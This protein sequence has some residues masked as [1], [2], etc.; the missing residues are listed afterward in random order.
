[1]KTDQLSSS[2]ET[3]KNR[4]FVL[5]Q[6][7]LLLIL[8][9]IKSFS[10]AGPFVVGAVEKTRVGICAGQSCVING[11][12]YFYYGKE[13]GIALKTIPANSLDGT[14]NQNLD[15]NSLTNGWVDRGLVLE[16]GPANSGQELISWPGVWYDGGTVHLVF[17]GGCSN[18][19]YGG[20][21]WYATST[22]TDP[23]TGK[24]VGYHFTRQ[25]TG[26]T[27]D[28]PI[29]KHSEINDCDFDRVDVGNPKIFEENNTW[30]L[31][32]HG[33]K[34]ASC[35]SEPLF[36][37]IGLAY[38]PNLKSL[39][40]YYGNPIISNITAL[41]GWET[42]CVGVG[43]VVKRNGLYYMIYEAIRC[44]SDW[45]FTWNL[46]TTNCGIG[47]GLACSP[48]LFKWSRYSNNPIA[49]SETNTAWNNDCPVIITYS[50][51]VDYVHSRC[52]GQQVNYCSYTNNVCTAGS[53]CVDWACYWDVT[54]GGFGT[55][56][57]QV[58]FSATNFVLE[59]E[60]ASHYYGSQYMEGGVT[61]WECVK[62]G[63]W[64]TIPLTYG[65]YTSSIP[66]GENVAT[67]VFKGPT[68]TGYVTI[69]T[70][71]AKLDICTDM[72]ATV[73]A[74]RI[75]TP[76]DYYYWSDYIY[77]KVPY[78]LK[79]ASANLEF[80]VTPLLQCDMKVDKIY[81]TNCYH[82]TFEAEAPNSENSNASGYLFHGASLEEPNA[83]TTNCG[84]G[85]QDGDHGWGGVNFGGSG[86]LCSGP[87]T[88][89]IPTG[90]NVAAFKIAIDN[91]SGTENILTLQVLAGTQVI[92]TR[93]VRR[94]EFKAP[95]AYQ[96]FPVLFTNSSNTNQLQ[97]RTTITGVSGVCEDKVIVYRNDNPVFSMV[98]KRIAESEFQG[99]IPAEF[100]Q[101]KILP[102]TQND[103]QITRNEARGL[104][105][106][107]NLMESSLLSISVFSCMG[108]LV[109][110]I[111]LGEKPA[112]CISG[113]FLFD[114]KPTGMY[115]V[116]AKIG[117]NTICKKL[118][119]WNYSVRSAASLK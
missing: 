86:V 32:F 42:H 40:K 98:G 82:Y 58:N 24:T 107:F 67:F 118:M 1:V 46:G 14:I 31:F 85:D 83:I 8:L 4:T 62:S 33:A 5:W 78:T 84:E 10:Q 22:G 114:G 19:P 17:E 104:S 51:S 43:N 95:M 6:F 44:P 11:T 2:K 64:A 48:N 77:V 101:N 105:Y 100:C 97:F 113:T 76:Y 94:E 30:Y 71:V 109:S 21:I 61:G 25:Y 74:E 66:T 15:G 36:L 69:T 93:I 35:T 92:A 54:A 27:N 59:A 9:S 68:N 103:F 111:N 99:D 81:S 12:I 50:N 87:K 75:I 65:P 45:A 47:W 49:L 7:F 106:R 3:N 29:L 28:G 115:L 55:Y 20:N 89:L 79:T 73:L 80:R 38:G 116:K 63:C 39:Q 57:R 52:E 90:N 70:P 41:N 60:N 119:L 112:G 108:K 18:C 13:G 72:G 37:N 96:Y 110:E 34:S 88:L 91:N 23:V 53:N 102:F 16:N 26:P 117:S 56:R